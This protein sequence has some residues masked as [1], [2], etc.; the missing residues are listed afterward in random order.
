MED[1]WFFV[2]VTAPQTPC[3]VTGIFPP[4]MKEEAIEYTEKGHGYRSMRYGPWKF[5][6]IPSY[7]ETTKFNKD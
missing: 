7:N 6:Q 1:N 3:H 4:E 2:F 5:G